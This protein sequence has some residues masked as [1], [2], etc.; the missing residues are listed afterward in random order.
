MKHFD[1]K[2]WSIFAFVLTVVSFSPIVT[3]AQTTTVS[4]TIRDADTNE[5][6]IGVN[7]LVKGQVIGT[8]SDVAGNF[9]LKV[10]QPPPFTLIFSMVGYA[11]QEINITNSNTTDL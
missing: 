8:I 4:G 1:I 6:L 5:S 11:S 9:N 2:T 10:S 3:N 7:I